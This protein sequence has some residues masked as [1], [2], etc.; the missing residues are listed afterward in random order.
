MLLSGLAAAP[1][2]QAAPDAGVAAHTVTWDGEASGSFGSSLSRESCDVTG[3]GIPDVIT[4]DRDW[5][6]SRNVKVGAG[7]VIKGGTELTGGSL[8]APASAGAI[9]IDGITDWTGWSVSCVGD[10][11]KDG[12]E[13][14]ALGSGSRTF[15]QVAV[16]YG[17]RELSDTTIDNLGDR[18]F[19]VEDSRA[20]D[21]TVTDGSTDNFGYWVG[22]AGDFD[23]DGYAD[24]AIGDL[25]ADNNGLTNSGS[26]WVVK[27]SASPSDVE[28]WE[29][30]ERII[31]R[32]DG[33]NAQDRL[34]TAEAAGDV[35]GDTKGDL[36][37]GSYVAVPWG[38]AAPAAGAGYVVFGGDSAPFQLSADLGDRGFIVAGALR[39][40]DRL[41]MSA[42]AVGDV[43]GDGLAD[44]V[45]GGDGVSN[46]TTG[47]RSGGAAVVFGSAGTAAVMT[48]PESSEFSVY[49]CADGSLT[50]DCDG[51]SKVSR[52]YY[53][54]GE[55]DKA[56]AGVSVA[57][58][59]DMNDDGVPDIGIG[60]VG[61]KRAYVV[62]GERNR[63]A[64][65]D[66]AELTPE[67]G[68]SYDDASGSVGAA[69]DL[70]QNGVRDFVYT[71]TRSLTAVLRGALN[72]GLNVD[73]ATTASAGDVVELTVTASTLVPGVQEPLEGTL[74]IGVNGEA[75]PELQGLAIGADPLVVEVPVARSGQA[76]VALEFTPNNTTAFKSVPAEHTIDVAKRTDGAGKL[77]LD[78]RVVEYGDTVTAEFTTKQALTG[79]VEF[80]VGDRV[81]AEASV[82]D[83]AAEAELGL[84]E[85]GKYEIAVRYLGDDVCQPFET[86]SLS[87][88]VSKT[89]SSVAAPVLSKT[90][91]IY[92]SGAVA[93]TATVPGAKSGNVT[94][95][96]NGRVL[97]RVA[98][99]ADGKA[100]ATL[101]APAAGT[102]DISA[103]FNGSETL[104]ASAVSDE[105]R[106]AVSKAKPTSIKAS[107]KKFKKNTKP[108]VT[109]R[110]GKLTNGA[111][112]VGKV[113]VKVG[114]YQKT[115]TLKASAKGK[116][117]V[118]LGKKY[119]KSI[120]VQATF[121]PQDT[122]NI[123]KAT[124]KKVKAKVKK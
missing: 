34:A 20:N 119:K 91:S 38:S 29:N 18:G 102:H 112:P 36:V 82:E 24:I 92:G 6:D 111:Y 46:A 104:A 25:L 61:T 15:H 65:L 4:G 11:N 89:L 69:G 19:I 32:I 73:G 86:R 2:A 56:R 27:G 40:R 51:S 78:G 31:T 114:S 55:A 87:L 58:I 7:Y 108:T 70:D 109:V 79:E 37:L 67:Q 117:T 97:A 75:A 118:K 39:A 81:L 16:I 13:D 106:L 3:D 123:S 47:P 110:V 54:N 71:G 100:K 60:A 59:G 17:S 23:G 107:A 45:I 94:F 1:A 53:I 48:D 103:R 121:T 84:L 28:V 115:A 83:G 50:A 8:N 96:D 63:A 35:N 49:S 26:V 57:G 68:E 77:A 74:D 5:R 12:I 42:A 41:G 105:T 52:G 62:Y 122:A 44:V 90:R 43:N 98:V 113:T 116:V 22:P 10:V 21:K 85:P 99:G 30:P 9:R 14:F 120:T 124:A 64:A 33:Q 76:T 72:T 88:R 95:Y 66:L 80:L 101:A 93:A